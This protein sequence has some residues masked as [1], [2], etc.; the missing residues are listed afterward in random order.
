MLKDSIL[1]VHKLWWVLDTFSSWTLLWYH[2]CL[3]S[4]SAKLVS[5]NPTWV[6]LFSPCASTVMVSSGAAEVAER[7]SGNHHMPPRELVTCNSDMQLWMAEEEEQ[8][9]SSYV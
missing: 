8:E 6:S 7:W 4:Y 5:L 9:T 3:C 2:V 1:I